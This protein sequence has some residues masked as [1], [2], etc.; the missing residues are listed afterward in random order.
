MNILKIIVKKLRKSFSNKINIY[1]D[2][3]DGIG[4]SIDN[5]KSII[6]GHI[7][8]NVYII[9]DDVDD[10]QIIHNLWW[11]NIYYSLPNFKNHINKKFIVTCSNFVNPDANEFNLNKEFNE[12]S[13]IADIWICPSIKQKEILD[14]KLLNTFYLPF[15]INFKL[16]DQEKKS[17]IGLC[18][19]F[20]IDYKIIENKIIIGSF[21]R[22]SLGSDLLKPKWQKNPKLLVTLLKS[23]P[24]SKYILLL[25]G[26]RRHYIINE[27]KIN[28]I[29]YLYLG[30]ETQDDDIHS[31]AFDIKE[32][33]FLYQ[34][35]DI[36][37]ITSKSEGGPKA[38]IEATASKTMIL[39]TDVGLAPDFI[40][41]NYVFQSELNYATSLNNLVNK[42]N[43]IQ[44]HIKD[45]VTTNYINCK[46]ILKQNSSERRL[47]E[48]YENIFEK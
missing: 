9:V 41:K 47:D 27:C 30:K 1:I 29:P 14:K 38:A 40:D 26:P 24:K 4:W 48:L 6:S 3:S 13:K 39:S 37:L 10:A 31:N 8:K 42:Y 18:D 23:L 21:Q 34:L 11:N 15:S 28:E 36:Y 19:Y 43:F 5:D 17:K 32:M 16:F 44:N 12:I 20:D 45:I 46:S 22:D 35:T 2:G 33:P 7:N 25:A